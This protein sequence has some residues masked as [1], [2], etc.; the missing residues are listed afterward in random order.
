MAKGGTFEREICTKLSLWYSYGKD[1]SVFYRTAGS[2]GRATHRRKKGKSTPNSE[3]DIGSLTPE[4]MR[5]T[6]LIGFELKRGY[7][8]QTLQDLLDHP[9][10]GRPDDSCHSWLTTCEATSTPTYAMIVRR[11]KRRAIILFKHDDVIGCVD[12]AIPYIIIDNA[13][14]H[15]VV[16]GLDEFLQET[17]PVEFRDRLESMYVTRKRR[18]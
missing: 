12:S 1:D 16:F 13:M 18:S 5:L 6:R 2:G 17:C 9:R 10:G 15:F 14:G 3:A 11:D 8:D 4:G 7:N